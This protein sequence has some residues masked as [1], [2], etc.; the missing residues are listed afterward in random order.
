M[1]FPLNIFVAGILSAIHLLISFSLRFNRPYQKIFR[2]YSVLINV[3]FLV[4][5]AG[6]SF[7]LGAT[8]SNQ[9]INLFLN[10]IS[11]LYFLLFFPLSILIL[12]LFRQFIMTADIDPKALKYVL[13]IFV[14]IGLIGLLFFGYSIF[15][16]TFY[17]FAP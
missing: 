12:V 10:G 4:F 14:S 16:Y 15:V 3:I 2:M 17:G 11:S 7:F 9:G 8:A 5:L 1:S 13:I 6:F